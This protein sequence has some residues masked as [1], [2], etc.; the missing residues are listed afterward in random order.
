L[1]IIDT[2]QEYELKY[3]NPKD[4]N[5]NYNGKLPITNYS[6]PFDFDGE[7]FLWVEFLK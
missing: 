6:V 3:F 7:N 5:R 2:D 1:A 4:I